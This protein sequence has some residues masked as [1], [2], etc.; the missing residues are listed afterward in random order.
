[1]K[2]NENKYLNSQIEGDCYQY[3]RVLT[4]PD[5]VK[6]EKHFSPENLQKGSTEAFGPDFH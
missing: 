3:Q 6:T 2:M 4:S 5:H 1:M